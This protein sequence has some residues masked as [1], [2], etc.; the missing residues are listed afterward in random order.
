MFEKIIIQNIITKPKF[1]A[2]Y[3]EFLKEEYFSMSESRLILKE[4]VNYFNE[5]TRV[6]SFS[7]ISVQLSQDSNIRQEDF[8][9]C[10]DFIKELD[11]NDDYH[12]DYLKKTTQKWITDRA[13]ENAVIEASEKMNDGKDIS[14]IQETIKDIYSISF[15]KTIGNS[16]WRDVEKQRDFYES[17]A[18]KYAS[19]LTELNKCCGGGIERKTLNL[20]MAPTS[21][22]K[23]TAMCSL[24]SSYLK[25]GLNVL[26][27]TCEMSEE[28]IRQRIEANFFRTPINDIPNLDRDQYIKKM[29]FWGS[30]SKANLYVKEYPTAT[31]SVNNLRA[32]LDNL[33]TKEGFIPDVVL[34][35]YIGIM[36]S[37]RIKSNENSYGYHKSIAE[38]VRGLMCERNLAGWS[39]LQSNRDGDGKSDL[40]LNNSA[41]SYGTPMTADSQFG[42]IETNELKSDKS[43]IWKCLKTRYSDLKGYRFKV[44]VEHE[45]GSVSDWHDQGENTPVFGEEDKT[46][47]NNKISTKMK[48]MNIENSQKLKNLDMDF[49]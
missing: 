34:I 10:V 49:S 48:A 33:E 4:I 31:C 8:H 14:Y 5:Y 36:K 16:L 40:E 9:N 3:I 26:Y 28:K 44:L 23:T 11:T 29:N 2:E 17:S 7:E 20:L 39:A 1:G 43:Q 41:E 19:N 45:Y 38:E 35:D 46:I 15:N 42:L 47:P 6:P 21:T 18:D 37:I 30:N 27:V 22:G 32:L 24:A 25:R 12:E 13:F